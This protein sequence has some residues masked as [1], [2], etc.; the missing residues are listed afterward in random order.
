MWPFQ[1]KDPEPDLPN[2][3]YPGL[4][5]KTIAAAKPSPP[6]TGPAISPEGQSS[7]RLQTRGQP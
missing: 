4:D 5:E 3:P 7:V 1:G 6:V 2:P